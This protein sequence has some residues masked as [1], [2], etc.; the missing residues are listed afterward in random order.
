MSSPRRRSPAQRPPSRRRRGLTPGDRTALGQL[1]R[2]LALERGLEEDNLPAVRMALHVGHVP[3]PRGPVPFIALEEA[4]GLVHPTAGREHG[5]FARYAGTC[6]P[7]PEQEAWTGAF[8]AAMEWTEVAVV[9]TQRASVRCHLR[10]GVCDLFVGTDGAPG[11]TT[12]TGPAGVPAHVHQNLQELTE[13]T[14][15][16]AVTFG[17]H[18]LVPP[19]FWV[20]C[21][22]FTKEPVVQT[23]PAVPARVS[24]PNPASAGVVQ[25]SPSTASKKKTRPPP[26]PPKLLTTF[27]RD[28]ELEGKSV[29]T[30]RAYRHDLERFAKAHPRLTEVTAPQI[31]AH[32]RTLQDGGA[33]T[34]T[35]SRALATLKAFYRHLTQNEV[36]SRNPVHPVRFPRSPVG[37]RPPEVLSVEEVDRL[38][39]A[40]PPDRPQTARDRAI[41]AL[42]YNT[43]IRAGELVALDCKDL[44]LKHRGEGELGVLGKGRRQ[45]WIPLNR[46]VQNILRDYLTV[47][48]EADGPLFL[49]RVG[50]RFSTRG[51]YKLVTTYLR[52]AGIPK[53][54]VHLLRHTF[55]SHALQASPNIRA[56]QELLGH[57]SILTTQRYTHINR[58][59]LKKQ[60]DN[61]PANRFR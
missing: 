46:P 56:I 32:L 19:I 30:L 20:P 28:L 50:R 35:V 31:R 60:V 44:L 54:G 6:S 25:A 14:G 11:W 59:D 8:R 4:E 51:L 23:L 21:V 3:T 34:A 15:G 24:V 17:D 33:G 43:G 40:V 41:L 55:A 52:R 2:V 1:D 39:D 7:S 37:R 9:C 27:L 29:H 5:M 36:L 12:R 57:R 53:T 48:G 45:R 16:V 58:E 18:Q 42:L 47:R 38:L 61:L 22:V 13:K 26:F 10:G 49:S